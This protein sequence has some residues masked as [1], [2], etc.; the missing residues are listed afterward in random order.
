MCSIGISVE[1]LLGRSDSAAEDIILYRE[2]QRLRLL[3][4]ASGYYDNEKNFK[5]EI[6]VS[7]KTAVLMRKFLHFFDTKGTHLPLKSLD[8]LDTREEVKAFEIDNKLTSRR[9]IERLL[10]EFG[11]AHH[12]TL[13]LK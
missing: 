8:L 10:E 4:I 12:V 2:T 13:H 11:G 7:T 6:L 9:S 5:R 1:E 3:M